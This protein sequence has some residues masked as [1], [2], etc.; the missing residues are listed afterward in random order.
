MDFRRAL[1]GNFNDYRSQWMKPRNTG[2]ISSASFTKEFDFTF[3][4]GR[5]TNRREIGNLLCKCGAFDSY[6]ELSQKL[7]YIGV[8]NN[9]TENG[10]VLI[11]CGDKVLAEE[12]VEKLIDMED[13]PVRRCHSY[14]VKEVPVK[15]NNIHPS[16]NIQRDVVDGYLEK[17][18]KVKSWHAQ[19]DP[20]FK[21]LTGQYIFVMYEED[22]K[23]NP[24]PTTVFINGVPASVSY[25]TR[26]KTC[27][28]CGKEGHYRGN[29]PNK[30]STV[31]K[32]WQCGKEGHLKRDCTEGLLLH[33]GPAEEISEDNS[34]LSNSS[35]SVDPPLTNSAVSDTVVVPP[36]L[37]GVRPEDE[38][39]NRNKESASKSEQIA[40]KEHESPSSSGVNVTTNPVE[41]DMIN[42]E[43]V[44][45]DF[46]TADSREVSDDD[47]VD[48]DMGLGSD[49]NVDGE[50]MDVDAKLGRRRSRTKT[51][52]ERARNQSKWSAGGK[53]SK[54]KAFPHIKSDTKVYKITANK[55]ITQDA[56]VLTSS[57]SKNGPDPLS[58]ST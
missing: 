57:G 39:A 53:G 31:Q 20:L 55:A 32:C 9:N 38:L 42:K 37:P 15:F 1:S 29:C 46:Q 13:S 51:L 2:S 18:G 48:S 3:S 52:A 35:V 34:P 33:R 47:T 30:D 49:D 12:I 56:N 44:E 5:P 58:G 11:Q 24:L 43:D 41:E 8:N 45:E 23:K 36:F 14:N 25:R 26:V 7:N 54:L 40:A 6:N 22:L 19:I 21:L 50:T 4:L 16:V 27:F 10:Q 17:F 28:T